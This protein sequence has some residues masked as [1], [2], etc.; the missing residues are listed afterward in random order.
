MPKAQPILNVDPASPTV[1]TTFTV[2]GC[3]YKGTVLL[4][5][6]L[7]GSNLSYKDV[8]ADKDGCITGTFT[9]DQAGGWIALVNSQ[10]NHSI[11][12]E[13]QFTVT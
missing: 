10:P 11:I 12:S 3:G 6:G 8:T 7:S 9:A 13:V 1:G 4:Q 2:S 5:A